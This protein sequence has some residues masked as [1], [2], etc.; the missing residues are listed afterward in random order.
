MWIV[1][2]A[3]RRPYS[4]ATLCLVILMMGLLSIFRTKTDVLPAVNIPVVV[5]VWSYSGLSSEDMESRVVFVAERGYSTSV[6]NIDHIESES[7]NGIG[8]IKLYMAND[9]DIGA[10]IG[11]ITAQSMQ[12]LRSMPPGMQPPSIL[13]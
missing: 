10:S 7:I 11:Q 12:S 1:N 9:A 4:V 8:L 2:L 13:Q 6:D 3:L 5:V